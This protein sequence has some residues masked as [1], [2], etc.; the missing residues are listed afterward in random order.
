M[1]KS[2]AT[3]FALILLG[4]GAAQALTI[5]IHTTHPR[6]RHCSGNPPHRVCRWV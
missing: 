6:H 3:A 5:A 2:I 4:A 1:K